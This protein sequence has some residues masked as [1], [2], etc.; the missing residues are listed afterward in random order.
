MRRPIPKIIS[1]DDD[2]EVFANEPEVNKLLA[3]E[4][5]LAKLESD[6]E[7]QE[8]IVILDVRSL[9]NESINLHF[10]RFW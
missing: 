4:D 10:M 8:P 3:D 2:D 7:D 9:T 5:Y 6:E 1:E